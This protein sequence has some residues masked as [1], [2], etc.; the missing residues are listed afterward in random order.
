[1]KTTRSD[2]APENV[3]RGSRD[4]EIA[5][6]PKTVG[7]SQHKQSKNHENDEFWRCQSK[8]VPVVTGPGNRPGTQKLWVIAHGNGEKHENDEF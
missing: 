1:M 7:Y 6:G 5:R 4:L 2:T 8:L 3:Y